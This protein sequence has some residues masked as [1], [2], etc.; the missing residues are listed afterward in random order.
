MGLMLAAYVV[1]V[2]LMGRYINRVSLVPQRLRLGQAAANS[3]LRAAI[4]ESKAVLM[5]WQQSEERFPT[6]SSQ[7]RQ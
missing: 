5:A 6:P 1:V 3:K 2:A 7:L 4:A